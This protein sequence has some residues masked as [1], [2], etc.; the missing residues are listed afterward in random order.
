MT[1]PVREITACAGMTHG[2]VKAA[3]AACWPLLRLHL[4]WPTNAYYKED[5]R[6][7][8]AQTGDDA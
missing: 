3:F 6:A 5:W 8:D 2:A 1:G 7:E 4:Y